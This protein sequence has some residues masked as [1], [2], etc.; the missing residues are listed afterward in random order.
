MSSSQA[1]R[2]LHHS[3]YASTYFEFTC[4]RSPDNSP[5]SA[6]NPSQAKIPPQPIYLFMTMTTILT[7]SP[8]P[9]TNWIP[10]LQPFK[11]T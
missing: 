2:P 4:P 9:S 3:Q 1:D 10:R 11:M 5:L 8:I 7:L 6:V